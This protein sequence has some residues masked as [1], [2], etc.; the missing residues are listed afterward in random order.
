MSVRD[1]RGLTVVTDKDVFGRVA[2]PRLSVYLR[3]TMKH[4][5]FHFRRTK[6]PRYPYYPHFEPWTFGATS[7]WHMFIDDLG[8]R[9]MTQRWLPGAIVRG[10]PH[11]KRDLAF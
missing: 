1:G 8:K 3:K 9:R 11:W 5:Q 10:C 6:H 2:S 4:P 7:L